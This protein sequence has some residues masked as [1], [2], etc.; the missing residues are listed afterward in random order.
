M[1][2]TRIAVL[3][4]ALFS[5]A[6]AACSSE[7]IEQVPAPADA[8]V[9]CESTIRNS[10]KGPSGD[11]ASLSLSRCTDGKTYDFSCDATTCTCST[12]GTATTTL[13]RAD[14]EFNALGNIEPSR[15][16]TACQWP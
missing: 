9:Y 14:I 7:T 6:V 11:F 8:G 10:G 3:T 4:A 15:A 5:L 2:T 1:N 13:P 12:N 16:R